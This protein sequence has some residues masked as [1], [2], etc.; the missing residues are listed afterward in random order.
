M[1]TFSCTLLHLDDLDGTVCNGIYP[2][3]PLPGS[4]DAATTAC[5]CHM[6]AHDR[7]LDSIQM[8]RLRRRQ[9]SGNR[10]IIKECDPAPAQVSS[11]KLVRSPQSL[12]NTS[13]FRRAQRRPTEEP[14]KAERETHLHI[15]SL[16][17]SAEV[18]WHHPL[19]SAPHRGCGWWK[20]PRG[21]VAE[22]CR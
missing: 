15:R 9:R 1:P 8:R 7:S 10:E 14:C 19:R 12:E 21:L 18:P 20:A 17:G 22:S 13:L 4:L 3:L 6:R 5:P 11:C 16:G 2:P